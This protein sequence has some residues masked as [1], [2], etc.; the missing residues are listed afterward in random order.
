MAESVF[1][2]KGSA[3][4]ESDKHLTQYPISAN[5]KRI[6]DMVLADFAVFREAAGPKHKKFSDYL[7]HYYSKVKKKRKRGQAN[8]PVPLASDTVDS[9]HADIIE[10]TVNA[11]G[12]LID[13]RGTEGTDELHSEAN[14]DLILHQAY[15][16]KMAA[17]WS[18][19]AKTT[20]MLGTSVF[21]VGYIERWGT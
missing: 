8:V 21:K 19:I 1:D 10:H 3:D 16:E 11:E 5:D 14:K 12:L 17:A 9:I 2:S 15:V 13:T 18:Q 20:V 4:H 6:R 7:S